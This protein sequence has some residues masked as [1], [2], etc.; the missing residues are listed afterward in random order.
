MKKTTIYSISLLIIICSIIS[1]IY[2]VNMEN[3]SGYYL[4]GPGAF[5]ALILLVLG[6][7]DVYSNK[8]INQNERIMWLIGFVFIMP[9]VG[10]L[11]YPTFKRRNA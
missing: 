2:L 3:N 10:L 8:K 5:F 6:L 4:L 7:K 1:G 11:Y 9:I